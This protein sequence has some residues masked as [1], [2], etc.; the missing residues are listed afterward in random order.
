VF[1]DYAAAI[2]KGG[3]FSILGPNGRGKTTLLKILLG[4]LKP[5]L[6][7]VSVQGRIAFVPQL[8]QV[9][10]DYSVLDMVLM[11]RAK[12]IGLFSQPGVVDEQ[13]ALAA[14][15]RFNLADLAER[16]FHEL[17]G[18]QR[19]MVIFARALVAEADILILDEPTSALDLK[20]QAL[21]LDWIARLSGDD[22]LT[23]VFTT[24]HPHHALAVADHA[25][26]M[27]A[28]SEFACGPVAEVLTE[29][30]LFRLYGVTMR[31]VGFEHEGQTLHSF[32]PVFAGLQ[33]HGLAV[34][35]LDRQTGLAG[36]TGV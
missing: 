30:H 14:L 19:Q 31:K 36:R 7:E 20:N 29:D 5:A 35:G 18:G 22:G 26:L 21:V 12:K 16:P 24:H 9:S 4:V 2:P 10:F 33:R 25:L 17:S 8:F 34:S 23:V 1:R 27:I 28:E 6:G 11:G 3:V 15:E 32:V 13:A